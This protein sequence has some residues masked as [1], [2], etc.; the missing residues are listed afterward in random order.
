MIK[1][2]WLISLVFVGLFVYLCLTTLAPWQLNKYEALQQRNAQL[3]E[4]TV[5]APSALQDVVGRDGDLGDSEWL[6]VTTSG[7]YLPIEDVLLR[8]QSVD[9]E[10]VYQALSVFRTDAGDNL[11]VNRG[12]VRVGEDNTVPEFPPVSSGQITITARLRMPME[13]PA[14]AIVLHDWNMVR[15][16]NPQ[17]IGEIVDVDLAA[18]YLQLPG[19]QPGS[20][21]PMPVPS[22]ESGPYLSYGLQWMAFGVLAPV[23]LGYFVWSE[24]RQRRRLDHEDTDDD[25][26]DSSQ[27]PPEGEHRGTAEHA[28][29][30]Q[31]G[32]TV[33]GEGQASE[34]VDSDRLVAAAMRDRYGDRFATEHRRQWRRGDRFDA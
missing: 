20:L 34:V 9:G 4:S 28:S 3:F 31:P 29:A 8:M 25:V 10:L 17:A 21:E 12:W 32:D 11:L 1:P 33:A 14:E 15:N 2:G 13:G 26:A 24:L 6:L 18:H 22:V 19:G 30:A 7:R 16:I 27:S 5:A 23:G